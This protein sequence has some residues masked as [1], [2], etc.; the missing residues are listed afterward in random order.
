M[1]SK[2]NVQ[3]ETS[4][5]EKFHELKA[6]ERE[7]KLKDIE[8]WNLKL[9][10]AKSQSIIDLKRWVLEVKAN[11]EDLAL[12]ALKVHEENLRKKH[13]LEERIKTLEKKSEQL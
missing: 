6:K 4:M 9:K 11:N 12:K 10:H 13:E 8:S 2:S 3:D 7:N 5:L 1:K